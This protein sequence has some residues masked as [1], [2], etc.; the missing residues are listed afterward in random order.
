M[1]H[2]PN[3]SFKNGRDKASRHLTLT[4][5][6]HVSRMKYTLDTNCIIDLEEKREGYQYLQEMMSDFKK[7]NLDLS[8]VAISASENQKGGL[9]SRTF[10]DF[11]KK[12]VAAGLDGVNILIPMGYWDVCYWDRFMWGGDP[13]LE[14][15]IHNI[16]FPGTPIEN[17]EKFSYSERKWRNNKCDVQV[18]WSHIYYKQNILVTRDGNFHKNKRSLAGI[19]V[20]DHYLS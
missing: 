17:P 19:G 15:K 1:K 4:L 9:P 11:E 16:L 18:A 7:G 12:I 2:K 20:G 8:I 5:E 10:E 3:K 13:E 14:K 6:L